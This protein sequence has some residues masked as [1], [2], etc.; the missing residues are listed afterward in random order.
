MNC[1][2]VIVYCNL[3]YAG[4]GG[5]ICLWYMLIEKLIMHVNYEKSHP[6]FQIKVSSSGVGEDGSR[7]CHFKSACQCHALIGCN[8]GER[9]VENLFSKQMLFGLL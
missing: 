4:M 6:Y 3:N 8:T 1:L 7:A 5:I 2:V 9:L